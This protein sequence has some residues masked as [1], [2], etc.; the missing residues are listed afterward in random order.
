MSPSIFL[1]WLITIHCLA[2]S[3]LANSNPLGYF[4]DC[5][6]TK[7]ITVDNILYISDGNYI[8][9]GNTT[10]IN[11]PNILPT[12]TTLRYFPDTSAKKYCYSL[13][14]IKGSKYIVK[15]I[16][17][18]GGFDGGKQPPVF[19][20]I[21]EGTRWNI[22]NTTNDYAKGLS[23]YYEVVVKSSGKTLN[24]CLARNEDTGSSSPFIST[25]EVK[26][27]DDSLYNPIDFTKYALVTAA[28]HTFGGEDILSYPDDK[29]DRM[30]QPFKDQNP[31]V[32]SHS[33]ITSSDFWNLPPTIA[34]INGIT[35]SRG[36]KLEIQWPPVFLPSTYYYISL[37][38]QDNRSP[39]PYS[40]RVFDVSINDHTFFKGLNATAKGITVYSAQWPLSGQTKLTLTPADGEP[41]GPV[42]NAGEVFQILPLAGRTL[43]RDVIVME[44]LARS[45]QNPPS[46][47][48]GDPCLPKRNS[49]TGVSCSYNDLIA[50]VTTLNLTNAG[51]GGS[52]P[53]NIG[54]LTSLIHLWLGGNKISGILPD[55]SRLHELQ[56]LH[57]ENNKLE[58]PVPPSLKK[59]PK[60][61]EINLQNNNF[62]GEVP[63]N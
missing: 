54:N 2:F 11:E 49:W 26:S 46:D 13:P 59:L 38:F 55:M 30:W 34:F 37:Y 48:N 31:I 44:D 17:Y 27:L 43:T 61:L 47:W 58:G 1:I 57:L 40:W 22:V 41:V 20:Q 3:N 12:L 60:L 50:R 53:G 52:L 62:Q 15:T 6:G 4:I 35:T 7:E 23:S 8:N 19:D 56:T 21:I 45:L 63:K 28:R 39:S 25:L 10:I 18:Y 9:V 42:I 51:L 5:G 33:N 16:Y 36:K 24:V 29:F 14:V 32:G